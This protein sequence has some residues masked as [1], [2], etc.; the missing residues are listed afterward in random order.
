M[1][2]SHSET[3]RI[4]G[5]SLIEL[6]IVLI[7]FALLAGSLLPLAAGQRQQQEDQGVARQLDLAIEALHAHAV[8]YG[9]LPC[10]ADPALP[11]D[12][13]QAGAAAC[14][15]EYGVLP[16]QTLGIAATDGWGSHFSYFADKKF[17]APPTD[18]AA[19]G[20]TLATEASGEILSAATGG[21]KLASQIPAVLISHG[22]NAHQAY[23]PDSP[24][25]AGGSAD[26]ILNGKASRS[27]V[28][29]TP[30]PDYDD[31]LRWINPAVLKL[32]LV[33]AGRLP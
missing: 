31:L 17:T 22:R 2:R 6:S 15:R 10:P 26:E 13:P 16:W 5:F 21:G 33:N 32:R 9:H 25:N 8:V 3:P 12:D 14:P 1:T 19:A 4:R 24:R 30:D 11:G 20:F 23:R 29:H 7:V 18:G 27:F 28:D